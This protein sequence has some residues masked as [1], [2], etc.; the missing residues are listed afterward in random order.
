MTR[1]KPLILSLATALALTA[2]AATSAAAEE[3]T[4]MLPES[5]VSFTS[6]GGAMTLETKGGSRLACA[7]TKDTGTIDSANL[8]N[9]RFP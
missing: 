6:T 1:I 2:L 7:K 3:K 4:K 5:G 8:G 9:S